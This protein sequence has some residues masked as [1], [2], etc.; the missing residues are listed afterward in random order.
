[1]LVVLVLV[2]LVRGLEQRPVDEVALLVDDLGVLDEPLERLAPPQVRAYR[3][4]LLGALELVRRRWRRAGP[5]R[6]AIWAISAS[7]SSSLAS[8][9]LRLD[10]GPQARGRP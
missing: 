6:S 5:R 4:E 9:C 7:T 2:E 8:S 3:R 10:D 1:V